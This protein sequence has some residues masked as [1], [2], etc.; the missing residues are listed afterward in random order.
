MIVDRIPAFND[1]YLWGLREHAAS[2]SAMVVD[3]GDADVIQGWLDASHCNLEAILLTH[4]HADH[5][6]GVA[7]LVDKY[8]CKVFGPAFESRLQEF[9]T[10]PLEQGQLVDVCGAQAQVLEVH[11]HTSSHIAYFVPAASA[12]NA[13]LFCGD[14]LFSLGCGRMFEGTA[15]Q[16]WAS[17]KTMRALPDNT[18]VYCAHE[19]TQSNARFAAHVDPQNAEL[20]A[21]VTRIAE[22]RS[23]H[24][25]TVPSLLGEE[26]RL[27]PFLRADI[28]GPGLY[29]A[30]SAESDYFG[31][32]RRAKDNF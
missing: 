3:P 20:K 32:M 26:K 29:G 27:N 10:H 16:M 13:A 8:Q 24:E 14:S 22:Q 6:G 12:S 19:Y 5:I 31:A 4:H 11:G 9:L 25:P 1:N 30:M 23:R 21:V 18:L 17:L 28:L 2:T 15:E 7:Q